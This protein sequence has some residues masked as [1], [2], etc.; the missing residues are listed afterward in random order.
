[1]RNAI[2]CLTCNKE[3]E[4]KHRHDWVACDCPPD[5]D[6]LVYIDG[7]ND[8]HRMGAGKNAVWEHLDD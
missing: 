2:R 4:S 1:M 8:Y 7:G 5:S 6:T 3:L